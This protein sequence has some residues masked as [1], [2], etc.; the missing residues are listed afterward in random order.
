MLIVTN[1]L[2]TQAPPPGVRSG[3]ADPV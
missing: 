3:R 1:D 2:V